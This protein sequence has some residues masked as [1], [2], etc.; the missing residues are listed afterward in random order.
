MA[1]AGKDL[2][3]QKA[4]RNHFMQRLQLCV[5]R[6]GSAAALGR[7]ADIS[8]ATIGDYLSGKSDPT[9]EKLVAIAKAAA[10][11]M[12]WLAVGEGA[13]PA[14]F[15]GARE[16]A[17]GGYTA[18]S[19]ELLMANSTAI[20]QGKSKGDAAIP[21]VSITASAGAGAA[22]LQES[23][24]DYI[25]LGVHVL[26]KMGLSSGDLFFMYARG[27][28][29]EPVI[30]GGEPLLC[31][32]A[33]R[34]MK[35]RDGI[36]VVRLEGDILVKYIQRLPGDKLRVFSENPRY[37]PFEVTLNDGVD[38]AIIGKVLHAIRRVDGS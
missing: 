33:E 30:R 17:K 23:V 29:M 34:H 24:D 19:A 7:A 20:N 31:S 11:P 16:P 13:P 2:E 4:T 32:R 21:V 36:F 28:S 35:A 38:F 9:R 18:A 12:G 25:S 5:D 22:V 1:K 10:V 8:P 15:M 6:L 37:E 3:F 14:P 27:E 26:K